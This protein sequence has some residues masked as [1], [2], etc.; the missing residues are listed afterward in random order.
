M[1]EFKIE[2]VTC[3]FTL[4]A[5]ARLT[6]DALC[7]IPCCCGCGGCCGRYKPCVAGAFP[8]D[9]VKELFEENSGSERCLETFAVQTFSALILPWTLC[10]CFWACCGLATPCARCTLQCVIKQDEKNKKR[11]PVIDSKPVVQEETMKR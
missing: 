10:G 5:C 7:C 11:T 6:V 4:N 1:S 2:D 3:C 9:A 8:E